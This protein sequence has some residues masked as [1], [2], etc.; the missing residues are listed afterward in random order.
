MIVGATDTNSRRLASADLIAAFDL[1]AAALVNQRV[2]KKLLVENGAPTTADRKLIQDGIEEITWVAALKP[3]GRPFDSY[4]VLGMIPAPTADDPPE[5]H[6]RYQVIREGKA[7]GIGGDTYYGYRDDLRDFVAA[8]LSAFGT[9]CDTHAI[10]LVPGLLQETLHVDAP[11]AFAHIDVDWYDPVRTALA[12]ILP[13]LSPGGSVVLDDYHDWGGCRRAVDEFLAS[14]G[15]A[16]EASS[17]CG[18]LRLQ[19]R[20]GLTPAVP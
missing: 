1:P 10:R 16:F 6:A 8:Q 19:R 12:R 4:D 5:V 9:P 13:W 15:D 3:A 20:T 14:A 18:P 11:V 2:P 7:T 17:E